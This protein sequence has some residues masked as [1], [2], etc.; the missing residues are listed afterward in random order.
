MMEKQAILLLAFGGPE[1][2]DDVKPFVTNVLASRGRTPDEA[3]IESVIERYKLIGGKSPLLKITRSQAEALEKVLREEGKPLKVYIGM[4][5][6]HP[7]IK[8]TLAEI[9]KDGINKVLALTLAPHNSKAVIGGYI[10]T[11]VKA[12]EELKSGK[13]LSYVKSWHAHP[14]FLNALKE[15]ILDGLSRFSDKVRNKVQLI[16][17]AHSLPVSLV[18]G[19]PYVEQLT[20]TI[21]GVLKTIDQTEG[22]IQWHRAYQSKGG[23]PV[24]WLGPD[25]ESVLKML[26]ERGDE[27]VLLIPVGFVSDHVEILYD[28]DILAKET[29]EDLGM[30]FRRTSSLNDSPAFIKAL[31]A[32]V[33]ENLSP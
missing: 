32:V 13:K 26:A 9:Q 31:A 16:F 25:I 3:Q 10:Q 33:T 17:S 23:G 29:A 15:K 19:D 7:F 6:W 20:E 2:L 21:N 22:P 4:R 14:L 8:D 1:S 5:H 24:E 12:L 30:T 28:I 27:N 11:V 18:Q